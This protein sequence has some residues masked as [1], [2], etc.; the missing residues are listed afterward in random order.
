MVGKRRQLSKRLHRQL[1]DY[2]HLHSDTSYLSVAKARLWAGGISFLSSPLADPTRVPEPTDPL[3]PTNGALHI[4]RSIM[5]MV[6]SSATEAKLGALFY[7]AK[8]S[9]MLRTTLSEMGNPQ[10]ATPIQTDNAV[11]A[12][13]A[14]NT[15]KQC[16]QSKAIDMQFY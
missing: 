5:P 10:P 16:Q 2:F 3:P 1:H 11:A 12:G 15:V 9:C 7:N 13:I 4:L 8:D 14:N 6:L